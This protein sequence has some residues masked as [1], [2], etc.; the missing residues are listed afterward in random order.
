[1]TVKRRVYV[2]ERTLSMMTQCHLYIEHMM[3]EIT[4]NKNINAILLFSQV[5]IQN[6]KTFSTYTIGI[7][8]SNFV[9]KF[10]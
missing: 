1:M 4:L 5:D 8:R 3:Q 6:Q 9:H 10:V 7:F 2:K